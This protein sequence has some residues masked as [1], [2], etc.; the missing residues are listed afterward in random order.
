MSLDRR[1]SILSSVESSGFLKACSWDHPLFSENPDLFYQ[2]YADDIAQLAA[3]Q[4]DGDPIP[5]VVY[6][7]TEN[8]TWATV[9]DGTYTRR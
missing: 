2:V 6:T 8:S 4:R 7:A 9:F 3:D 1:S 5:R